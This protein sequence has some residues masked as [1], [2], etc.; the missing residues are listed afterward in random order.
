MRA[1]SQPREMATAI[2]VPKSVK[3]AFEQLWS[4]MAVVATRAG[5]YAC[6][7]SW[8]F[9][10]R[11]RPHY[12]LWLVVRGTGTVVVD[13]RPYPLVPGTVLLIPP[14]VPHS[15]SHDPTDPLRCYV[16]HF[17]LRI[18][19]VV[20]PLALDTLPPVL[21]PSP[22]IWPRLL[23][24][25]SEVCAE[26]TGDTPGRALIANG[27]M[28][29]FLGQ[30]WREGVAQGMLPKKVVTRCDGTT[31]LAPVFRYLIEHFGEPLSLSDLAS[32]AGFSRTHFCAVFRRATGLTP[33]QYLQQLRLQ[34]AK[35]LL[36]NT[37]TS[38]ARI[39]ATV[40]MGD[41]CYFT[42]VFT[43]AEG[44]SPTAYRLAKRA[45]FFF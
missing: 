27:V 33:I 4:S 17:T 36:I 45:S 32:L 43:H 14:N 21:H 8:G 39:A 7:P 26:L 2:D 35:E 24:Y 19:G 25:A 6:L 10:E 42:R 22:T 5:C 37:D 16:L 3:D 40:G 34:H 1:A 28:A 38:I 12:Q 29:R 18:V 11:I 30:V 41:P 15:G 20:A 31:K 44:L 9:A 23:E 13:D